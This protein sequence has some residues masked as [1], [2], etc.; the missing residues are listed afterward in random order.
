MTNRF[1]RDLERGDGAQRLVAKI[2]DKCNFNSNYVDKKSPDRF[3]WD[4]ITDGQ[5]IN[6]TT[7]VKYDEYESKSGNIA[8]ET[9]NPRLGKPS[10]LGITRAFFWAHVLVDKIVWLTTVDLLRKFVSDS[11]PKRIITAG[12]DGNA[13]IYLYDSTLILP[14]IF[15]RIDNMNKKELLSYIKGKLNG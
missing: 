13:T 6:F 12:G 5:G 4:I 7:E 14:A 15:V 8:I 1:L 2:Y 10:G 11:K 3:F 9:Y